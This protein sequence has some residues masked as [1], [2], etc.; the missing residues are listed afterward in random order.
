M[1]KPK[2][3]LKQTRIQQ[4]ASITVNK[5]LIAKIREVHARLVPKYTV[6]SFYEDMLEFYERY[7]CPECHNKLSP[8]QCSCK[9]TERM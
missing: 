1:P 6:S 2:T 7:H 4:F 5:E 9:A 3:R 8:K